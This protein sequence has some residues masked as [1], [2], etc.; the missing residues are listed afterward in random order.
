MMVCN[1]CKTR[2]KLGAISRVGERESAVSTACQRRP[3][4]ATWRDT[5]ANFQ[6]TPHG[7]PTTY[8][9][10]KPPI[11]GGF[12]TSGHMERFCCNCRWFLDSQ[13]HRTYKTTR[14]TVRG[15]DDC[16]YMRQSVC[17][18]DEARLYEPKTNETQ[19]ENKSPIQA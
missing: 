8:S 16:A 10:T 6:S 14:C 13:M 7:P 15:D 5:A 2:V 3:G 4:V 19:A 1:I 9:T 17:G 18:V 12:F 11:S